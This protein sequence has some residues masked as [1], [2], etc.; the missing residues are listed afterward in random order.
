MRRHDRD[1]FSSAGGHLNP[2]GEVHG[3]HDGDLPALLVRANGTASVDLDTDQLDVDALFDAD[4]AALIVHAERDNAANIPARYRS[5]E[6]PATGGPDPTTL[7]TGDSGGRVL[8]GV[9]QNQAA[10]YRAVEPRRLLDTRVDGGPLTPGRT[11]EV[12]VRPA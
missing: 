7:Q 6:G 2:S 4:G 3:E 11:R 12:R 9:L 8:C 10:T 1:P 5:P